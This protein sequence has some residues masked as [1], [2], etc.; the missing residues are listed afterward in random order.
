MLN[1]LKRSENQRYKLKKLYVATINR[2]EKRYCGG[3]NPYRY[4]QSYVGTRIVYRAF[5]PIG[6]IDAI[7]GERY[8]SILSSVSNG[9]LYCPKEH[10]EN[11]YYHFKDI[12]DEI[13]LRGN[14]LT[15]EEIL[16][17]SKKL[18]E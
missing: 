9:D 6:F 8:K 1:F 5:G 10:L 18:E 13:C 15:L 16:K 4:I 2:C 14:Y 3:S 7:T 11:L 17:Y 12:P